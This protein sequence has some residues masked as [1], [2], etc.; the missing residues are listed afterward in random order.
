MKWLSGLG[1]AEGLEERRRPKMA[2]KAPYREIKK[3]VNK[4]K[5]PFLLGVMCIPTV[6]IATNKVIRDVSS[7]EVSC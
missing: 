5:S 1:S 2:L 4:A 7:A 6:A 3:S